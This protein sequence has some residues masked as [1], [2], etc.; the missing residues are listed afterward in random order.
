MPPA[1]TGVTPRH[2]NVSLS[3]PQTASFYTTTSS[4]FKRLTKTASTFEMG[5]L[6][7]LIDARERRSLFIEWIDCLQEVVQTEDDTEPILRDYPIITNPATDDVNRIFAQFLRVYLTKA[8]KNF[9]TDVPRSNG[10][11]TMR[12]LQQLFAPMT[13]IDM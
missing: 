8:V 10:V 12:A 7:Y 6:D 9:L 5:K 11:L 2:S 4:L 3:Y 13:H 1:V